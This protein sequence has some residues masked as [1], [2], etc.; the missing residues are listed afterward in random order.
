MPK[1]SAWVK[2]HL[3]LKPGPK[4]RSKDALP[5]LPT[6]RRPITPESF[7]T[8]T[9]Q[10]FQLPW[11]VRSIIL[12]IAFGGRTLHMDLVRQAETWQWR[13]LVCYQRRPGSQPSRLGPWSSPRIWDDPCFNYQDSSPP[14]PGYT[15]GVMGFLLS[16]RQAYTEGI[17]FLYSANCISIGSEPL[18]LNLPRMIAPNRL[19]SV[20]ALDISVSVHWINGNNDESLLNLFWTLSSRT[21]TPCTASP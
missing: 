13:G 7:A 2:K 4:K 21:V 15:F 17:E 19:S 10:L 16:C 3:T 20:T 1:F 14:P 8:A 12:S 11:D 6:P 9:C 5:L 18:L